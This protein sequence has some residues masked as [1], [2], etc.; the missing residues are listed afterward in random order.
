MDVTISF[1]YYLK[2]FFTC[3]KFCFWKMNKHYV[4][5]FYSMIIK[6]ILLKLFFNSLSVF[7]NLNFNIIDTFK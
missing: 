5:I 6:Y 4:F 3:I 2:L 1:E 7:K